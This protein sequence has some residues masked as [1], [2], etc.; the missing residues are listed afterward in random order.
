MIKEQYPPNVDISDCVILFDGVCKLC[1][2]WSNFIIKY[3]THHQFKLCS[4]QSSEGQSIL[5]HFGMPTDHFDTMLYVE[6]AQ[7]F[8][9]SDAFL[10]VMYKLGFPWRLFY[11][12]KAIPK[13]VRNWLYDRIAF[14]RYALFGKYQTCMLPSTENNNRFLKK[15]A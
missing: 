7:Y 2:A 5:K 10:K 14:N 1:H 15:K 9:Q 8:E 13:P 3:D 11:I 6:G 12:F 4:V